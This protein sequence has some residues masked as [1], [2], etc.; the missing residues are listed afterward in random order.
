MIRS[1]SYPTHCTL[2]VLILAAS[3]AACAQALPAPMPAAPATSP[4]RL[5]PLP[6]QPDITPGQLTLLSLE[7]R[8]ADDVAKRGGVGFA[9][10]FADD[11]VALNNGKPA[12]RGRAAIAKTA[13]WDPKEYSLTWIAEGASMGQSNDMGYTWGSYQGRSNDKNGHAV[14][15]SGR[16]I[17]VWKKQPDGEWKVMLDASAD[18]PPPT[19]IGLP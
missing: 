15:K 5:I 3:S 1:R 18:A 8:F 7:G 10:W 4:F 19:G 11:A 12:V 14:V 9:S 2:I 16:Y 13:T 17:T 6:A